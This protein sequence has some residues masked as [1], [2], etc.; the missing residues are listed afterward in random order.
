MSIGKEVE[1]LDLRE[2]RQRVRGLVRNV[3][4]TDREGV[5]RQ[6]AADAV[7]RLL[8]RRG[9]L[10]VRRPVVVA[11]GRLDGEQRDDRNE[12]EDMR[13]TA[14]EDEQKCRRDRPPRDR[15]RFEERERREHDDPRNRSEN[16]QAVRIERA[17]A[18]EDPSDAVTDRSHH[19]DGQDEDRCEL[20]P[21]R[22]CRP[23]ECAVRRSVL[24][25]DR[26]REEQD[27]ADE[28]GESDGRPREEVR[29]ARGAEESDA[30]AEEA[31][32]Q[33]EVRQVREVDV[34]G[35]RPADER[36]LDEE[37]EK[38]ERE[39]TRTLERADFLPLERG[40]ERCRS[41]GRSICL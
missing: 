21:A 5:A 7:R 27:E 11:V 25:P 29:L 39:E 36:Q 24:E 32:E 10:V 15:R 14:D 20:H 16:V 33:D 2:R 22:E 6:D 19:G 41:D 4:R 35:G 18:N 3:V 17:E 9:H 23:A 28:Y 40:I 26:N 34:V 8:V 38:A 37:H 31:C 12:C 30:D 13:T 1:A